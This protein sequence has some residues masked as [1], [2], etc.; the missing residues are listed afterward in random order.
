MMLIVR[1]VH[2]IVLMFIEHAFI[3]IILFKCFAISYTVIDFL[4]IQLLVPNI[5]EV[6]LN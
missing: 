2:C 3:H 4:K 6:F 1:H 5:L